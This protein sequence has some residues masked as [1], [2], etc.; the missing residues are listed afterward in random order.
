MLDSFEIRPGLAMV[1][2]P[3]SMPSAEDACTD[4]RGRVPG[5]HFFICVE[6]RGSVSEWV[7]TSS[8]AARGRVM[9]RRKWGHPFWVLPDTFADI[10]QV[11]TLEVETVR[12]ASNVDRSRRTQRNYASLDFL[13]DEGCAAA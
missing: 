10:F 6:V 13:Y 3:G 5:P 12:R 7:A 1:L 9:V 8:R 2:D 11:W 4:P